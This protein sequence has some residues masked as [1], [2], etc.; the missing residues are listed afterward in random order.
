[1]TISFKNIASSLLHISRCVRST[2]QDLKKKK[3]GK[4]CSFVGDGGGDES[5]RAYEC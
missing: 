4:E 3:L 5:L 1:M 2:N